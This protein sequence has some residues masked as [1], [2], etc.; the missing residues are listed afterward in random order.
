MLNENKVVIV[1]GGAQGI[2]KGIVK[3]LFDKGMSVVIADIDSAAAQETTSEFN[4]PKKVRP[5]PTDVS[6]ELSVQK[7]IIRTLE[8]FGRIDALI[9]NAGIAAPLSGPIEELSLKD[10][11]R[12]IGINLTGAFL[13]TKHA[14]P[15]L[16]KK[17]GSIVNIAS[18]RALQ[19]ESNTEAY[20]ASKGG[21]VALTHAM[22]VSL[23]P[24]VRVNCI[25]PGWIVVNEWQK[26]ETRTH[27]QLR[28]IDHSQ[29]PC[30]RVGYPHDIASMVAFLISEEAGFIT[31]QNFIVDGG[32]TRKMI[33]AE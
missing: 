19:S 16:Q 10:W 14:L 15:A 25:S 2:G 32:M 31:G 20:A 30:G 27:A 17:R 12:V 5:I 18:T 33:Y 24:K 7:M 23:G 28:P 21:I 9:N 22:A 1:T 29:H 3:S 11:N 8:Y 4:N 13:C 26:K 6:D